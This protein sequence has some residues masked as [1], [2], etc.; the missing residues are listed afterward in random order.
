[1]ADRLATLSIGSKGHRMGYQTIEIRK[2]TPQIGAEILSVD[3]SRPLGN[4]QFQEVHD[5][6]MD[7]LVI[8]FRDQ[9]ISVEQRKDFVRRFG[10]LHTHPASPNIVPE[11]PEVMIAAD[12][13]STFIAGEDWHSDVSCDPE[14]PYLTEVPPDGGGDIMFAN[15]YLAYETLSEPVGKL[16]DGLMA[17]HDGEPFYRG[18][19]GV[20]D[21]GRKYPRAE[22]PCGEVRVG[23]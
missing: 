16:V 6:L 3:L 14:R 5:A 4:Q 21:S 10:K 8:F 13:K 19:Y 11:H 1:V 2:S 12:A 23:R 9:T 15:M 7:R 22:H 17:I 18:R 20:D